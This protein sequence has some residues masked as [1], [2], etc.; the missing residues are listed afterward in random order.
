MPPVLGP[1]SPSPTRLKSCA[2]ASATAR[3]PSQS[4]N[5]DTSGPVMP[6]SM[7]TVRPAS[8]NGVA[9]ELGP[10]VGLG[11]GEVVGDE[12][13]LAGG[14]PVGLHDVRRR[15]RA[16]EREGRLDVGRRRRAAR[17]ARRPRRPAPS[18]TPSSPRPGRRRRPGRTRACPAARRRSASP[19]TSGC[20]GP[21]T[22]RSASSSSGGVAT[23][24]GMPGLPGVTTTS[25][26]RASTCARHASRPP[27]PT[28]TTFTAGR[29]SCDVL[30]AARGRR[31]RR[32]IGTPTCCS[33]K[34]T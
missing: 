12:H 3:A 19:S 1:V 18:C 28:T 31:P 21:I 9:G 16:Q 25:A 6:S 33:R 8:P 30:V 34:A 5:T 15:Q 10:H 20:S 14:Q 7:T 2:G 4:A 26:V 13:A 22:N 24:P 27:D 29:S 11:L 17:W 23:E 32:R